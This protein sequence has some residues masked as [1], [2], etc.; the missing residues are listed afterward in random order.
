[1]SFQ[2]LFRAV[3][4]GLAITGLVATTAA[5]IGFYQLYNYQKACF[6]HSA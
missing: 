1:M 3:E 2:S 4:R 6:V 5:G